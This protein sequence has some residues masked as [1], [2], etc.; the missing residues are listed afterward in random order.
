MKNFLKT[1]DK[2]FCKYL[3]LESEIVLPNAV[4]IKANQLI[5]SNTESFKRHSYAQNFDEFSIVN[6]KQISQ[7]NKEKLGIA[8]GKAIARNLIISFEEVQIKRE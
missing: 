6:L 1:I 4:E 7:N 5:I 8:I 2:M 3:G